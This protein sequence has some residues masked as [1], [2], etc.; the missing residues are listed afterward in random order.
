MSKLEEEWRP[1]VGYEGLYEVSD[2]G[3]V[4]SLNYRRTG[5]TKNMKVYDKGNGYKRVKL[6]KNRKSKGEDLHRLVAEA[7]IPNPENK[8]Q[9]DHIIP[10][11]NGG[12]NE[13]WN[14]RWVTAG[15]NANNPLTKK[16]HQKFGTENHF[17][18]KHHTEKTKKKISEK[19]EKKI[20]FQYSPD[21]ELIKIWP[22]KQEAVKNGFNKGGIY[23]AVN[24]IYKTHKG[25][26]WSYHKL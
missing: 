17:F 2:W 1:V 14:L 26:I 13:V 23:M 19:T 8:E 20:L 18:G 6:T 7:F 4:I 9:V 24:G 11:S 22:S 3:R 5:K 12:T 16:N 21:G 10:I 15:E 25:F